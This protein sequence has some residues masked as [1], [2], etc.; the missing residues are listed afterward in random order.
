M[1]SIVRS[2]RGRDA[3]TLIELLVVIAIIA[4]LAAILFPVFAQAREKARG[5][6]CLSNLKQIGL[7]INMYIQDYDGNYP[8]MQWWTRGASNQVVQMSWYA[9]IYPYIKNG[10]HYADGTAWGT[11][12]I[13]ACPSRP[14]VQGGI[15]GCHQDL[16][17][18]EWVDGVNNANLPT[19][20]EVVV[21][22]PASI[23]MVM[24]NGITEGPWGW[25][26]FSAWEWDLTNSGIGYNRGTGTASHDNADK[27]PTFN[28]DGAASGSAVW[29]GCGMHARYR[30][31]GTANMTFVD[32]H[33]KAMPKGRVKFLENFF[34]PAGAAADWYGQGWYPY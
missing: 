22:K 8:M 11:D 12:G 33:A 7:G 17:T 21:D 3:F 34:V 27:D 20:N 31:T 13:F 9:S 1:R 19:S 32:G 26:R 28:C 2:K 10:D 18:D 5:T 23:I 24:E 4:I 16:F 15:Y 6:S 14:R 25:S 30:H 29:A